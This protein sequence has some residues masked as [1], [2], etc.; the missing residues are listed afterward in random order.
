MRYLLVIAFGAAALVSS[1]NQPK[2]GDSGKPA[3][4]VPFNA[5]SNSADASNTEKRDDVTDSGANAPSEKTGNAIARAACM[6]TNVGGKRAVQKSQTFAVDFEPFKGSCFV[7]SYNP[8]Y[9]D[10]HM[11][12]ALEIYKQG[13]KLFSFPGQFNGSTFGCWAD[14]VAFQDLNRDGLTDVIVVGKCAAKQSDYNENM[15]YMNTGKAFVTRED[16]NN[17]LAD[18]TSVKEITNFVQDNQQIFF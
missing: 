2:V 14:A 7:T 6:T 9:G 8:E 11:E 17:K 15:V 12:T 18:L 3:N 16:G 1:C 13:K 5:S 4:V 10:S